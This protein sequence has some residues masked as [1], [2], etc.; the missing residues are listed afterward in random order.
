MAE[1][2]LLA[3][4]LRRRSWSVF[5]LCVKRAPLM[6]QKS[7]IKQGKSPTGCMSASS[8]V[9]CVLYTHTHTHTHT[10]PHTHTHA[11]AHT[12]THLYTT[13]YQ[14]ARRVGGR[15]VAQA[16]RGRYLSKEPYYANKRAL[17]C[18][19][20]SPI[21]QAEESLKQLEAGMRQKSPIIVSNRPIM[22]AKEPY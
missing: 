3:V 1:S 10:H 20:K 15:R 12:H 2:L 11:R 18:N 9:V 5:Y 19:Q 16:A 21:M 17:L 13:D 4:C 22:Q 8:I 6:C 7:P 14:N